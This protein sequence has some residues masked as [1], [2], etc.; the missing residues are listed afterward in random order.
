MVRCAELREKWADYLSAELP[1]ARRAEFDAHLASCPACRTELDAQRVLTQALQAWRVPAVE[2]QISVRFAD[3][4]ATR[5]TAQ[6]SWLPRF[7]WLG[8]LGAAALVLSL[9]PLLRQPHTAPD[10]IPIKTCSTRCPA[11]IAPETP[12]GETAVEQA[13]TV[14]HTILPQRET[15]RRIARKVTRPAPPTTPLV[16][17]AT[18][19]MNSL[20]AE[21]PVETAETPAPPAAQPTPG[22]DAVV[23]ALWAETE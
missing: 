20:L 8:A 9:L 10:L 14:K 6:R 7:A 23:V 11:V 16:P 22:T 2:P 15:S 17:D 19:V 18:T 5:K 1:P 12:R 3:A 13:H 21:T 4:L